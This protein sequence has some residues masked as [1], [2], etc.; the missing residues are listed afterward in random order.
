MI[1]AITRATGEYIAVQGSGDISSVDRIAEQAHLLMSRPGVGVVG[2]YYENVVEDR[3]VARLRTPDADTTTLE[4]LARGNVFTH[5]EVMYR[6]SIYEASG[7]YRP[8]FKYCQDYDLWLRMIRHASFATVK[9]PLYKRFIQFDGVSYAPEKAALQ[10]LYFISCQRM[11]MS[12]PAEQVSMFEQLKEH[13]PGVI[14]KKD[15]PVLQSRLFRNCLRLIAWGN[16]T[17][18][19]KMSE[20]LI[21][22]SRRTA[23]KMVGR[24]FSAPSFEK[25]RQLIFKS[26]GIEAA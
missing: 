15:D 4:S 18:A 6:R 13:G 23:I 25:P 19:N 22:R 16:V 12:S 9:K 10:A 26:L 2:S 3:G 11:A 21:S 17:Q 20:H 24:V 14:V 8:E 1:N 7:G 5:G